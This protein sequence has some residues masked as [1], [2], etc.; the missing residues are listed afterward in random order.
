M[1]RLSWTS[2]YLPTSINL[3]Y[4]YY[5][6]SSVLQ[7]SL[8]HVLLNHIVP[9]VLVFVQ[10]R[11]KWLKTTLHI[12]SKVWKQLKFIAMNNDI[13]LNE[14]IAQVLKEYAVIRLPIDVIEQINE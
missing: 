11:K 1:P 13:T 10:W 4:H 7:K 12:G 2:R 14:L 9:V 6:A 5:T 8:L 3:L